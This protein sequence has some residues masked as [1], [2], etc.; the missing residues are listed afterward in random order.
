MVGSLSF[1]YFINNALVHRYQ[2]VFLIPSV[3]EFWT[4]HQVEILT[5]CAGQP[6][7]LAGDGRCDSPGTCAKFC[8]Y[9]LMDTASNLILSS[10]TVSRNEVYRINQCYVIIQKELVV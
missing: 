3:E 2:N 8:T 7:I 10:E 9:T 5:K 6:F 4:D 1:A